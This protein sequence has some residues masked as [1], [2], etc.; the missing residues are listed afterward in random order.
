MHE[1]S[2]LG[3]PLESNYGLFFGFDKNITLGYTD[4]EVLDRTAGVDNEETIGMDEETEFGYKL[5]SAL[6]PTGGEPD[7]ANDGMV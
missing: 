1:V 5:G 2:S 4:G 6:G 3:D 7:G